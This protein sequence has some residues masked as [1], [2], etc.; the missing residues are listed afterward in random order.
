MT[1]SYIVEMKGGLHSFTH[2]E[3]E[4]LEELGVD[5]DVYP[6]LMGPGPYQ[7]NEGWT[8]HRYDR[9]R[10]ILK[11]PLF[12]LRNPAR[13]LSG[14]REALRTGTV[15]HFIIAQEFAQRMRRAGTTLLHPEF[16][17]NKMFIAHYVRKH[18][19]LPMVPTIHAFELYNSP[20]QTLFEEVLP[21]AD[22]IVTISQ[23]NS[24]L[25]QETYGIPED[26][27]TVMRLFAEYDER[28]D[29][30][31]DV[32]EAPPGERTKRLLTVG[33]F[34]PKKGFD[35]LVTA[36]KTLSR[37]D[38]HLTIVGG[39]PMDVRTM[40]SD[41][42][43]DDRVTFA[44]GISDQE[45]NDLFAR[46]DI[47]VLPSKT[48]TFP[49]GRPKDREGIPVVLMEAAFHRKPVLTTR[50]A[51]IPELVDSVLVDEGSPEQIAE[52]LTN[53]LDNPGEWSGIAERNRALFDKRFTRENVTIIRD[54]FE[55]FRKRI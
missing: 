28:E 2:R 7:P 30:G 50:H 13:Y 9:T 6:I 22:H 10:V 27:L 15:R 45:M 16:G 43:L 20:S 37:D 23:F 49:D 14:L 5:F 26:R 31:P 44:S 4:V 33:R 19:D 17:D 36:L 29:A 38:Y 24:D 53:M 40:V 48:E 55:R 12:F 52:A 46:C 18:L 8:V 25:I 1:V 35:D 41:A 32:D 21:T 3:L 34:V 47:F 42:G 51:G 39:G 54:V 11:Q